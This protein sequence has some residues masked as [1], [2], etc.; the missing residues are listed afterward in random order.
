MAYNPDQ[1]QSVG[2]LCSPFSEVGVP[3]LCD[4]SSPEPHQD[5]HHSREQHCLHGEPHLSEASILENCLQGRILNTQ[6]KQ[7]KTSLR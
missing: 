1:T 3:P 2:C 7:I 4:N 5:Q 6:F